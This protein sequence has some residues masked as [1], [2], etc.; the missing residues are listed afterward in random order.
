MLQVYDILAFR[1]NSELT[2][3][4]SVQFAHDNL[5]VCM[6]MSVC[7]VCVCACVRA[8]VRTCVCMCACVCDRF[9]CCMKASNK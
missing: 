6:R 8:C 3:N 7:R 1:L 9:A 5:L 4:N 2:N